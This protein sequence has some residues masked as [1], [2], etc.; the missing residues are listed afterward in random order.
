MRILQYNDTYEKV[1]GTET[2]VSDLLFNL[3]KL[4]HEVFWFANG[5]EAARHASHVLLPASRNKLEELR[6][7]YFFDKKNT[8]ILKPN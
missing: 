5:N 2:Y 4:G 7:K 6:S 8:N 1:G 3:T